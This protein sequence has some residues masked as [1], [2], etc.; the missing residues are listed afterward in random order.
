MQ[1]P[2]QAPDVNMLMVDMLA[3]PENRFARIFR[4]GIGTEPDGR[5]LHWDEL[6]RRTPP[7]DLTPG[8]WWLAV[9]WRREVLR[10]PLLLLDKVGGRFW[11]ARTSSLDERLHQVDRKLGGRVDA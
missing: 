8:E 11:F 1:L 3:N 7:G 9:G 6:R 2:E 5:Y 4:A 10:S